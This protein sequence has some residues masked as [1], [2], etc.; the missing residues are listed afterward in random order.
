MPPAT[1]CFLADWRETLEGALRRGE[2]LSIEYDPARLPYCRQNWRGA[3]VWNIEVVARLHPRGE[4][5]SG[6]VLKAL[7]DP[8]LRQNLIPLS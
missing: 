5:L 1:I 8:V 3:E 2:S 4:I 6:S 7:L